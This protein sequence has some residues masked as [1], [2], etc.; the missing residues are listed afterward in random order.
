M[1]PDSYD[2]FDLNNW[3]EYE[4]LYS[5]SLWIIESRDSSGAHTNDYHGNFIPQIA[6]QLI[7]RFTKFDDTIIDPFLGAGTSLIEA[8]R[9]GRKGVGVELR[10]DIAKF[11]R[12]NITQQE[13]KYAVDDLQKVIT[14]DASTTTVINK[15]TQHLENERAS[16]LILHPPYH[17]IIKFSD[18]PRCLSNSSSTD[19]FIAALDTVTKPYIDLMPKGAHVALIMADKYANSQ[20]VP[21][22]FMCSTA[23]L[24]QNDRARLKSIIVK[25]IVNSKGKRGQHRLWRYR[26]FRGGFYT[27]NHEYIFLF[28]IFK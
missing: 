25:N 19:H 14:G 4:D 10:P 27:F 3:K 20:L 12:R 18:D 2:E 22:G 17:D 28:E 8:K 7:R 23:L 9:L 15:V 13:T 26:S 16:L 24:R 5:E 1:E 6:N 11:A 21:L